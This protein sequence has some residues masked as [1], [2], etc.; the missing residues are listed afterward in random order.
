MNTAMEQLCNIVMPLQHPV[1]KIIKDM[2]AAAVL[3]VSIA[4]AVIGI[5]IFS[6]KVLLLF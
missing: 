4:S 2:A 5:I 6:P 1:I 3:I